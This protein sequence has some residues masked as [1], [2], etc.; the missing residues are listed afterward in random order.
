MMNM[1]RNTYNIRKQVEQISL[2]LFVSASTLLAGCHG[3]EHHDDHDHDH[4]HE[5]HE[6]HSA[7]G[8][9]FSHEMS[10][11]I[12]FAVAPV[13]MRQMGNVIRSVAKVMP[14]QGDEMI[15]TAKVD[16]I[17]RLSKSGLALGTDLRAGEAICSINASATA[18]NNL[19]AQQEQARAEWQRA[20]SEL[21]RMESLRADQLVLES[22]LQRAR[23]DYAQAEAQYKALQKG[24]GLGLQSVAASRAGFLKELRVQEGQFVQTGDVVAV[25]AQNQRL[26]LQAEVPARRASDLRKTIGATLRP[27]NSSD[28][29]S[30]EDL[31]GKLL[32]YGRQSVG[33]S[34]FLTV[35]FEVDA[36][37]DLVVGSMVDLYIHTQGEK[38]SLCVPASSVLEE[39]GNYFVYVQVEPEF[40]EKRQVRIGATDGLYT[41][42][43]SGLE[44]NQKVVSRGAVLVKLQQASGGI[45]PHSGHN[46]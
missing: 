40:Y 26:Q 10:E 27:M 4:E 45:D 35:S 23:A 3:H 19:E 6:H 24:F 33:S 31:N 11:S 15:L 32:A 1:K 44:I 41:E 42:I 17:V 8:V 46:H 30:L 18:D 36:I 2:L 28:I 12:D 13:E 7:N 38:E 21:E 14:A 39:M 9:E 25:V 16:G 34:S 20:K 5:E 37:D 29:L 22:E 43:L